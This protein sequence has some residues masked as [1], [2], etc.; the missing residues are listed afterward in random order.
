[1]V[2]ETSV[3]S[4]REEKAVGLSSRQIA[5]LAV[6]REHGPCTDREIARAIGASDPNFVR[7]RRFELAAAGAIIQ[8]IKRTCN[9]T[10]K[11]AI[12]WKV[13]SNDIFPEDLF[14]AEAK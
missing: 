7:P 10:G 12:T 1:M 11:T 2:R 8:H 4:Y 5:V 3:K 14:A 6:I 9:V 13:K